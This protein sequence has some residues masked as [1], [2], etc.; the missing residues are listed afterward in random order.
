[1]LNWSTLNESM[2]NEFKNCFVK[3]CDNDLRKL[4][5]KVIASRHNINFTIASWKCNAF[6]RVQGQSNQDEIKCAKSPQASKI[7]MPVR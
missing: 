1:M 4:M 7:I 3:L 6:L 5:E 2:L